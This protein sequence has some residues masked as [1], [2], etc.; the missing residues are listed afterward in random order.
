MHFLLSNIFEPNK[1]VSFH[2]KQAIQSYDGV[3]I[4]VIVSNAVYLRG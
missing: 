3:M 4:S 1:K 2:N